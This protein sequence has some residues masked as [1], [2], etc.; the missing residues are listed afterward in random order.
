MGL[1]GRG[2]GIKLGERRWK[3]GGLINR[4]ID[5]IGGI[6]RFGGEVGVGGGRRG[7]IR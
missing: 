2:W 5:R 4:M 7:D 6:N 3:V 1:G